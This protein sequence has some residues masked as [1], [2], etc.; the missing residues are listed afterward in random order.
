MP[1]D[2]GHSWIPRLNLL[3][4]RAEAAM[5]ERVQNSHELGGAELAAAVAKLRPLAERAAAAAVDESPVDLD[6]RDGARTLAAVVALA[7]R[8]KAEIGG[9]DHDIGWLHV[10][11][12]QL[13][14]GSGACRTAGLS[15]GVEKLEYEVPFADLAAGFGSAAAALILVATAG[16]YTVRLADERDRAQLAAAEAQEVTEF[17]E[18]LFE[19]SDPSESM[20]RTITAAELL[21]SGR[22]RLEYDL[23][24]QPRVQAALLATIG[25]VYRNLSLWDEARG[26]LSRALDIRSAELGPDHPD[27]A[28]SLRDLAD[29][30]ARTD[31]HAQAD[32]LYR[33]AVDMGLRLEGADSERH[34]L[35][36]AGLGAVALEAGRLTEA[37]SLLRRALAMLEAT[38]GGDHEDVART[39]HTL[40]AVGYY[41]RDFQAAEPIFRESYEMFARLHPQGHPDVVRGYDD[42]GNAL[43]ASGRAEEA[44]G[45]AREVIEMWE[46]LHGPNHPDVALAF[47]SLGATLQ[48]QGRYDEAIALYEEGLVRLEASVG[49]DNARAAA[50][51]GN[52]A[53]TWRFMGRLDEAEEAMLTSIEIDERVYGPD[54]ERLIVPLSMLGNLRADQG[55][56]DEAIAIYER[57]QRLTAALGEYDRVNFENRAL[58]YQQM[59][60]TARMMEM[61]EASVEE[62]KR[63][64]PDMPLEHVISMIS[65]GQAQA[66]LDRWDAAATTFGEVYR[67]RRAELPENSWFVWNALSLYG[68]AMLG[69]DDWRGAEPLLLEAYEGLLASDRAAQAGRDRPTHA[70]DRPTPHLVLRDGGKRGRTGAVA[71]ALGRARRGPRLRHEPR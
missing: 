3:D 7:L 61:Y 10:V 59:G 64:V 62:V 67:I 33:L 52:M 21:E 8:W 39:L 41:E 45:V 24:D 31:R 40:A 49:L 5:A 17:L 18:G 46:R 27:I 69:T 60:D 65:L 58:T 28:E 9:I 20:G 11:G 48:F 36:I 35:D 23:E 53:R 34:A 37:D 51:Y 26:P 25:R 22:E 47:H 16:F 71:G 57:G 1:G 32:S 19:V 63:V 68:Y 42:W 13:R 38:H 55:R 2:P 66:R 4:R 29:L 43:S 70:R 14:L 54:N 15:S 12:L 44:E 6:Y 50:I 30:D 56:Y